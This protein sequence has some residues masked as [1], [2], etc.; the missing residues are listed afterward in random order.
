MATMGER[1]RKAR[2]AKGL[3]Q[4]QLAEM[5]GVKSAGVISNWEKNLNKPD[6]DKIIRLCQA[7][8]IS[9]S[10]LLDYYGESESQNKKS[11]SPI[12]GDELD[13]QIIDL[14]LTLTSDQKQL[15]LA[16]LQVLTGQKK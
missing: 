10:Y 15:L 5:I 13:R 2:E 1:I 8:D 16:Q 3:Y 4:A 9:A 6:A 14:L 7:L 12:K 11:S